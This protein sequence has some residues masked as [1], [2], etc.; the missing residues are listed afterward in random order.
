MDGLVLEV[1]SN[2]LNKLDLYYETCE[3]KTGEFHISDIFTTI[4]LNQNLGNQLSTI[5][6]IYNKIQFQPTILQVIFV[7]QKGN[8]IVK[9]TVSRI[10]EIANRY[11]KNLIIYP[12][13]NSA[14]ET[15]E[16][17]L[18]YI[19]LTNKNNVFLSIHLCHELAAG[20]G[21][22]IEEVITK[23][24]PFI[25]SVS[26][27]GAS[28]SEQNDSSL[29]LWYWGIKPLNHGT[30]NYTQFYKSLYKVNYIGPIAIHSWGILNN[31][32]LRPMDHIPISRQILLEIATDLCI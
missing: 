17:A 28:E 29:P 13:D 2:T 3:I 21:Y 26:I 12:H 23:A 18:Y 6:Q 4:D 11:G 25:K 5:D 1:T 10:A 8:T 15:A 31:F 20:N 14:I 16:E 24:S 32:G 30:Y 19:E 22:R 27:S 9:S 7:G